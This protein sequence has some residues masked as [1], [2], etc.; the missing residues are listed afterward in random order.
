MFGVN[1]Q[2]Y[3]KWERQFGSLRKLEDIRLAFAYLIGASLSD[4]NISKERATSSSF[5]INL[6][7]RATWSKG[8]G[9]R[10]AYYWTRLGIPV[11]RIKDSKSVSGDGVVDQMYRWRSSA[12]PFLTWFNEGVLCLPPR[13]NHTRH[14]SRADW[15]IRT[16]GAFRVKVLQGLSDGD[17]WIDMHG[18]GIAAERQGPFVEALLQSLGFSSNRGKSDSGFNPLIG[19][20]RQLQSLSTLPVFLSASGRQESLVRVVRMK[21]SARPPGYRIEDLPLIRLIQKRAG[22]LP[23]KGQDARIREEIFDKFGVTIAPQG[24]RRIIENGLVRLGIDEKTVKAYVRLLKL[25]LSFPTESVSSHSLKVR[26]E[27]GHTGSLTTYRSWARRKSVPR[28]VK[29]A[30]SDNHPLIDKELLKAYPHLEKFKSL[31]DKED[32]Q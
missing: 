12:N 18:F 5:G 23:Q 9:D 32:N 4:G 13:G 28:A 3:S 31:L 21:E 24:I 27:T 2:V 7:S 25:Q 10:V 29:R 11:R 16:D 14:I 19:D 1:P 22:E 15:I 6:S 30:I 26:K 17:G 8:F 20:K